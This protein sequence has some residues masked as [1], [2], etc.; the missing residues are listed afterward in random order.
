MSTS[1]DAVVIGAGV[2]G[3]AIGYNL[4]KRGLKV[5]ILDKG[6]V[7]GQAS[8]QN[9]GGVRQ[10]ARDPRE[11]PLAM[12]SV[13]LFEGLADELGYDVEYVQ[14]GN[15]RLCVTAEHETA[16]RDAVEKQRAEFGLPV[17]YLDHD[18]VREVNPHVADIVRG[19]SYCPTDG[20]ANPMLTTYAFLRKA[21]ALGA[22]LRVQETV[23][24]I[25][26]SKGRVAAVVTNKGTYG[27]G[28]VVNVAGIGGRRVA[29]MVGLDFP[30]TPVFTEALVTEAREPL[31]PQMIGTAASDFYGHQTE[32]GSFVWG[33]FIGYDAFLYDDRGVAE[34]R[35]NYP[36]IA[37]AICRTVLRYFPLL[38][39]VHVTRVWSGLIAQVADKVP[40]LGAVAETPGYISAT[41]FSGHGF[42][43]APAIGRVI[44]Q[45]ALGETPDVDIA[46]F[47]H[48]RFRPAY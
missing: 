33:G 32:H 3:C 21:L 23:R 37:S 2:N 29:N 26:R 18:A 24:S 17:E 6:D 13:S 7:C 36:E 42:G 20:H 9:G 34:R 22:E 1:Y 44:S 41:G 8:G 31:F 43:I 4:A 45:V 25:R 35:P 40:V 10:S 48:D 5:L 28:L 30:M 47:A 16:M 14:G 38:H 19:A 15:L 11:L 27:A 46:A 12:Y 39:D